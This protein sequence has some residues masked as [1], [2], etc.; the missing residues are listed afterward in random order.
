MLVLRV[1]LEVR[2]LDLENK[3]TVAFNNLPWVA[4]LEEGMGPLQVKE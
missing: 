3:Q 1:Q 4:V 2:Q